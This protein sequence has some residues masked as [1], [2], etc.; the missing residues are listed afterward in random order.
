[1][2]KV[3]I[4]IPIY[5]SEKYL[6]KCL[7]SVCNQTLK[8]IEII[9]VNDCS[10]DNSLTVLQEYAKNDSRI[11]LIDF[12]ENKGASV[13]R[14]AGIEASM[15]EYIGF[16]DSDDFVDLDFYEKLYTKAKEKDADVV[17][18]N[19]YNCDEKS[20][21]PILSN[22]YNMNDKIRENKAYFY[23]GFT[24]A[25]Y[26]KA[27]IDR[28]NIRFP[29]NISHFEDPY[30]SIQIAIYLDKI[31]FDDSAHYFY[32]K[33]NDS[34]T[35]NYGTLKKMQDFAFVIKMLLR[36]FDDKQ[37]CREEYLIYVSFLFRQLRPWCSD[38]SL[39]SEICK[40]AQITLFGLLKENRYGMEGLLA[41]YFDEEICFL[42]RKQKNDKKAVLEM[43]RNKMKKS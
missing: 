33:H 23:Y 39:S 16:V 15:G 10:P 34:A 3:S 31:V 35:H 5:N 8:D 25:I 29:E 43:L 30:F 37:I 14:N 12:I 40:L 21:N 6:N 41:F 22:F 4:I 19:I 42:R 32:V 7:D 18:G 36:M 20:K 17:K 13:A 11:K 2:K 24:S 1:M 38:I 26:K 28:H 27:L 9:C